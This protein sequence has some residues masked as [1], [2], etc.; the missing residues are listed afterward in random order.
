MC[1]CLSL[2]VH[3]AGRGGRSPAA[4]NACLV[5]GVGSRVWGPSRLITYA[6]WQVGVLAVHNMCLITGEGHL[7][8]VTRASSRLGVTRG[9]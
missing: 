4:Y 5:E 8:L 9:S 3:N 1:V 6:F 7:R 2:R